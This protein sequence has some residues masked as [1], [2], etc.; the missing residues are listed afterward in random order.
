MI[1]LEAASPSAGVLM[2]FLCGCAR[3]KIVQ[4]VSKVYY[5]KGRIRG[6]QHIHSSH[7]VAMRTTQRRHVCVLLP[8]RQ[9]LESFIRVSLP[10]ISPVSACLTPL[11]AQCG[12][13]AY[14][15]FTGR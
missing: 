13:P 5:C 10:Q 2:V 4:G 8:N 7:L 12:F 3:R 6:E 1:V 14:A 15:L 9:H 11:E